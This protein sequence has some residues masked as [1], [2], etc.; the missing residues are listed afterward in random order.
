MEISLEKIEL[1]K[2]RTGVSYKEAKEALLKADGNV[3]DAIIMIE[4]EIDITPQSKAEDGAF[5]VIESVKEIVKKG[6]ASKIIV[7]KDGN[8][9]LNIPVNV[10]ILGLIVVD[11]WAVLLAAL[12]A[13]GTKCSVEIVKNN[14]EIINVS[15]KATETF[16]DV[17]EKGADAFSAMKDQASSMINKVKNDRDVKFWEN[18]DDDDDEDIEIEIYEV[19]EDSSEA[20][21]DVYDDSEIAPEASTEAASC[22]LKS[23]AEKNSEDVEAAAEIFDDAVR[24]FKDDNADEEKD[25]SQ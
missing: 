7:K 13:L 3:L 9:V 22:D 20:E 6:N 11:Y 21:T 25:S 15:E 14:G 10:G 2:D 8:V 17:K 18:A 4:D 1:V 5:R 24:M 19:N 12:L 23:D 16:S